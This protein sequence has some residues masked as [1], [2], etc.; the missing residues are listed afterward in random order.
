MVL[1]QPQLLGERGAAVGRVLLLPD[2]QHT[3]LRVLL[4]DSFGRSEGGGARSDEDI[5]YMA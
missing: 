5:G 4:P 3:G 1:R 2:D